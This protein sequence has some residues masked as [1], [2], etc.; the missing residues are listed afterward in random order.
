M[1][2][3]MMHLKRF[4]KSRRDD[5]MSL[6]LLTMFTDTELSDFSGRTIQVVHLKHGG[7]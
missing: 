6:N 7:K 4:K 1:S 2:S 3:M 5:C